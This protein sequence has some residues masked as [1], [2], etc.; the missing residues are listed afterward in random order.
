MKAQLGSSAARASPHLFI[1]PR[2]TR[3][4]EIL[5][6]NLDSDLN[7]GILDLMLDCAFSPLEFLTPTVSRKSWHIIPFPL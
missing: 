6:K 3:K 4:L 1:L 7:F 2:K 5:P